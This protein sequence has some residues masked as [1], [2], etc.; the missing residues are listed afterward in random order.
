MGEKVFPRDRILTVLSLVVGVLIWA[1]IVTLISQAGTKA[2]APLTGIVAVVV[3]FGLLAYI[4][5]KSAAIAH[6]R[7]NATEVTEYQ[8]PDLRKQL[9]ECCE[10]LPASPPARV[11][12]VRISLQ[13]L[14]MVT[15]KR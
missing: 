4:F 8:L 3:L 5:A 9:A 1:G 14:R 13:R 11:A 10:A 15:L 6:L 2:L 12:R 7:G